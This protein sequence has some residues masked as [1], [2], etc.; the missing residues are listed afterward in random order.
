MNKPID[1]TPL[2]LYLNS[3]ASL[4]ERDWQSLNEYYIPDTLIKRKYFMPQAGNAK[5]LGSY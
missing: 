3:L 2:Q 1:Y 4:D 5:Q